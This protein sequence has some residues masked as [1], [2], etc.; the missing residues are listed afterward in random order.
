MTYRKILGLSLASAGFVVW[1]CGGSTDT[2][3]GTGADGGSSSGTSAGGSGSSSGASAGSGSGSTTDDG[4]GSGSGGGSGGSSS[5]SSS[6]SSTDGGQTVP[7]NQFNCGTTVANA[8]PCT[9]PDVCCEARGMGGAETATCEAQSACTTG[10]A[11]GCDVGSCPSGA[12]CCATITIG[13]AGESGSTS[14]VVGSC[15]GGALQL[16]STMNPCPAGERCVGAGAGGGNEVCRAIPDGGGFN[17]DAGHPI[18]D[19]AGTD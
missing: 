6:G 7:G 14:C 9:P 2:T 4:G 17:F 12:V 15:S 8:M 3:T 5:G 18:F 10:V 11:T 13:T 16:C 1:A 19:A